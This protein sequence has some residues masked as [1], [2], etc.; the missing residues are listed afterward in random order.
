LQLRKSGAKLIVCIRAPLTLAAVATNRP[1]S[2]CQRVVS[3][4]ASQ[5]WARF[6]LLCEPREK[7][8][9]AELM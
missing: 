1:P 5:V 6:P 4:A 2:K 7:M 8:R 9:P 3:G